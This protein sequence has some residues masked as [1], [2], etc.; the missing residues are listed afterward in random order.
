MENSRK[1]NKTKLF[2]FKASEQLLQ[3]LDDLAEKKQM[4]K[5]AL[6]EYLIRRESDFLSGFKVDDKK[7]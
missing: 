3:I 6:I 5:G 7:D 1:I 4:S 2:S